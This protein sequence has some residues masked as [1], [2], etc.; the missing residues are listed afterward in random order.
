MDKPRVALVCVANHFESGGERWENLLK[1]AKN[2]LEDNGLEV[3]PASKMVWDAA[4][5]LDVV[6]QFDAIAPDLLVIIHVT[7]VCDTIQYIFVNNLSC[8]LVL[9]AVPYTETF[10]LGCVQHFGSILKQNGLNYKYLYGLPE[11]EKL[12]KKITRL[13]KTASV[14][15]K[16]RKAR[17]ALIGPRQ[18]W[19]VANSQDMVKEEWDFSKTFGLTIIHIEMDE[20]IQNTEKHSVEE[21]EKI[22]KDMEKTNRLGNIETEMERM[23]YAA[24]VYLG[25]KDLFN[26]YSL[27]AAAAECYP[28]FS[29]LMNLPSSWLADEGLIVDTE[30]DIGHTFLMAALY[31]MGKV[32]PVALGEIGSIDEKRSCFDLAHEGS[33]AHSIAEKIS[34]VYIQESDDGTIVGLP[35]KPLPQVTMASIVGTGGRYKMLITT[36][37]TEKISH[38]EWVEGGRKLMVRV[39]H[40]NAS[41]LFDK[42]IEEG[43]DHHLLVKEGDVTEELHDFCDIFHLEKVYI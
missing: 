12:I 22:L 31:E 41:A 6:E 3:L 38:K 1:G 30:G 37:S 13:S 29:G 35:F 23:R 40:N 28:L 36:G 7:W 16:L 5:A 10:S 9:W 32:G 4:D 21:A 42:M 43:I 15:K 39:K 25:V 20:L 24:K 14:A 18:T 19:R 33:T 2:A 27:T 11:N 26:R 34:E 17:I 8:P